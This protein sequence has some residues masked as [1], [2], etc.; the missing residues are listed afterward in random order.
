MRYVDDI[1]FGMLQVCENE[2][3]AQMVWRYR[4]FAHL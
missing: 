3:I 1:K 2:I 4:A